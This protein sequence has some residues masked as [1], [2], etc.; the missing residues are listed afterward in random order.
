MLACVMQR[1]KSPLRELF[2]P[3]MAGAQEL[4][5]VLNGLLRKFVPK[6]ARKIESFGLPPNMYAHPWFVT[7]FTQRFP[8]E[9]V[10]RVWDIFLYEDYKVSVLSALPGGRP[11]S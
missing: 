7:C 8:Y 1:P 4:L 10:T 11:Q 2:L 6:L 9:L 5:F 3:G